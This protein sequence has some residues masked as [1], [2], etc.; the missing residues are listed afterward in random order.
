M[1][2]QANAVPTII[3]RKKVVADGGH[4]GGAWKVAYADFVTAMMAFFMMMW[5]LNATTE[6]QRKGLADYFSPTIPISR[7]SAGGDGMFSGDTLVADDTLIEA[8]VG[9]PEDP[10]ESEGP[11]DNAAE[12]EAEAQAL[13]AVQA[14]LLAVATP[15][16]D[17]IIDHLS[18]RMTDEGLV[19][20]IFDLEDAVLFEPGTDT[21]TDV[22]LDL[23]AIIEDAGRLVTNGIAIEG[24]V[25]AEPIVRANN[26]VWNLSSARA[27]QMRTLLTEAGM[28]ADRVRRVTG[29]ADRVSA[30]SNPMS[31]RN[32]RLEVIFLRDPQ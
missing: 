16:G 24:H 32:N 22:L 17:T 25:A 19:V 20:E 23:A 2:G 10:I 7:Q 30:V 28:A 1:A 15:E 8:G 21:P 9:A 14:A 18:L 4:H 26:P 6:T 3:K 27:D 5:L 29:H 12:V 13:E 11:G 31:V